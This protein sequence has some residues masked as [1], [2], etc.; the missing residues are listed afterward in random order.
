VLAPCRGFWV[1]DSKRQEL[2]I[3]APIEP[4]NHRRRDKFVTFL[5]GFG[6]ILRGLARLTRDKRSART[7]LGQAVTPSEA[8]ERIVP[9]LQTHVEDGDVLIARTSA[10]LRP[11]A[12]Q[13][14]YELRLRGHGAIGERFITFEHAVARGDQLAAMRRVRL[15]SIELH[16][17]ASYLLKDYRRHR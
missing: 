9:R 11:A 12:Q 13:F 5:S 17:G 4:A 14:V 6:T 7:P 3:L 1:V 8:V 10:E 16:D 2:G 15:F